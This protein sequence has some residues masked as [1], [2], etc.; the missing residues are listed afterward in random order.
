MAELSEI[1]T[2]GSDRKASYEP[3]RIIST[4]SA[5]ELLEALGPT[6]ATYG[7]VGDPFS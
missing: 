4:Y 1:R 5:D 2:V 6:L 3:P 7:G